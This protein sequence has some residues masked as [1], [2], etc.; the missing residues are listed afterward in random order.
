MKLKHGLVYSSSSGNIGGATVNRGRHGANLFIRHRKKKVISN[1][2][3]I[4]KAYFKLIAQSWRTLTKAQVSVFNSTA[5]LCNFRSSAGNVYTPSGYQIFFYINFYLLL[6]GRVIVKTSTFNALPKTFITPAFTCNFSNAI[7][8]IAHNIASTSGR[9][10]LVFC[11][12]P[13]PASSIISDK[14]YRYLVSCNST[15]RPSFNVFALYTALFK[16]TDFLNKKVFFKIINRNTG[17]LP[18]YITNYT[19]AI[20]T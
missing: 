1:Q 20:I 3:V 9:D 17:T 16:Y 12:A 10:Y 5:K 13:L 7:L 11:T 15:N 6:A 14:D 8:N 4:N 19:S 2:A 18:L